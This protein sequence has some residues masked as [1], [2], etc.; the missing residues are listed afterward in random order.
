MRHKI[1]PEAVTIK[2]HFAGMNRADILQRKGLYPPPI[3]ASDV[4]GLE[5]SGILIDKGS[6]VPPSWEIGMP[7]C[8]LLTGGG[9]ANEVTTHYKTLL[10]IP[11]NFSMQEA[12]CL[13][14]ALLTITKNVFMIG[15][16]KQGETLLVHGGASGIGHMAIQM[17]KAM[18]AHVIALVRSEEKQAFCKACG[19]D[20]AINTTT[21]PDFVAEINTKHQAGIDVILDMLGAKALT[22]N[23]EMLNPKGRLV[24]IATITGKE[25]TIDLRRIMQNQLTLTG[26]TL[27]NNPIEEKASL[28]TYAKT[29]FYPHLNQ[30]RIKPHID[31]VFPLHEWENA[32]AYF[33]TGAHKG[34][35]VLK[36]H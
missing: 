10:P 1:Q 24:M 13:P 25:G 22:Q 20:L 23:L 14:E 18:G 16:L 9:Y 32:H 33:E 35:V 3:G 19:A 4:L 36:I 12:A 6:N 34:K 7:V 29:H 28:I 8:A 26:S 21:H 5:V 30:G 2:T 15:A 31:R 11:Q 17:A 27:R